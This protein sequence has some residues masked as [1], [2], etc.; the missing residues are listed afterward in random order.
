MGSDIDSVVHCFLVHEEVALILDVGRA[1]GIYQKDEVLFDDLNGICANPWEI[2][3]NNIVIFVVVNVH[4]THWLG[5][6]PLLTGPLLELFH[7]TCAG[8]TETTQLHLK[9]PQKTSIVGA[10]DDLGRAIDDKSSG[11]SGMWGIVV[12]IGRSHDNCCSCS[13]QG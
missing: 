12:E 4:I 3:E 7:H 9:V 11:Y 8:H 5:W 6:N 13:T 1:I 10:D 2:H